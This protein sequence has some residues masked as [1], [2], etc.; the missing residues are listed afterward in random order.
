MRCFDCV[1]SV[2]VAYH[3]LASIV[4]TV[5]SSHQERTTTPWLY[6]SSQSF[7]DFYL[8]SLLNNKAMVGH[9]NL[10]GWAGSI[11]LGNSSF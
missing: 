3:Y 6:L 2:S 4:L 9:M 11:E 1:L 8:R 5:G 10:A 7:L